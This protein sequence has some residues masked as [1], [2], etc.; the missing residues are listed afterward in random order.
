MDV[1]PVK[2]ISVKSRWVQDGLDVEK[3]FA[4]IGSKEPNGYKPRFAA[5]QPM[6]ISAPTGSGKSTFILEKLMPFAKK[7]FLKI[8]FLSNRSAITLQQKVALLYEKHLAETSTLTTTESIHFDNVDIMTYQRFGQIYCAGNQNNNWPIYDFV[9]LDEAHF[10][11]SDTAFN[12]W[13]DSILKCLIYLWADSQ[14][15]YMTATPE[16]VLPIILQYERDMLALHFNRNLEYEPQHTI[17]ERVR[18]MTYLEFQI[19]QFPYNYEQVDLHF[20]Q[21][22]DDILH[23]IKDSGKNE[24]WLLFVKKKWDGKQMLKAMKSLKVSALYIDANSKKRHSSKYQELIRRHKFDEKVLIST[25]VLDCGFDIHDDDLMHVVVDSADETQIKQMVGRKRLT[26]GMTVHLYIRVWSS[27]DVGK[28]LSRAKAVKTNIEKIN[29]DPTWFVLA[30]WG[31]LAP[32]F[33]NLVLASRGPTGGIVF[34]LN[35]LAPYYWNSVVCDCERI[36]E[37]YYSDKTNRF[38]KIVSKWFGK[39]YSTDMLIDDWEKGRNDAGRALSEFVDSSKKQFP[40]SELVSYL[41]NIYRIVGQCLS[42]KCE[43]EQKNESMTPKTKINHIFQD[44]QIPKKLSV[45]NGNC[46]VK[47]IPSEK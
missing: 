8:L 25:S 40:D 20:F 38:Q 9:I 32:D 13:T 23:Q 27:K 36:E 39:E 14:R 41:E 4:N 34:T 46:D 29:I 30:N 15:I 19:Y 42:P 7:R 22:W 21:Q 6:L 28:R 10:F 11:Y 35:S 5:P 45:V 47:D 18:M 37:Y 31:N 12:P 3:L 2:T 26:E 16:K 1:K 17:S 43:K 44:F 33:Q 24:K